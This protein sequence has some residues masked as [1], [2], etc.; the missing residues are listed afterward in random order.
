M[1][2][3]MTKTVKVFKENIWLSVVAGILLFCMGLA[4]WKFSLHIARI[5][6][7][8]DSINILVERDAVKSDIAETTETPGLDPDKVYVRLHENN[9]YLYDAQGNQVFGP[10]KSILLDRNYYYDDVSV[11]RYVDKNGLI[12]YG[13]VQNTEITIM[14]QGIYSKASRMVDGSACVKE[15]D[16]YYYIDKDGKRFTSGGYIDAYPFSESQGSYAR[17][18]KMDGSWSVI[19]R[20][21]EEVLSGF[22]S[23]DELPYCTYIGTGIRDGKVVIFTLEQ[24]EDQ[25]PHIIK[26][27]EECI[28]VDRYLGVDYILVIS[29]EG[30]QGVMNIWN[31]ES[32]APADYEDIQWGYMNIG[33]NTNIEIPWFQCQKA[34][35]TF[36]VYY[37]KKTDMEGTDDAYFE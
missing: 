19:N 22:E 31:G 34:D 32:V 1:K 14:S 27:V 2:N 25:Q 20:Q 6:Q 36:D 35:G 13:K 12:G 33:E 5:S 24:S 4:G 10:C 17:V 11:F 8:N 26:E 30:K 3:L 15:G 23:I 21:E 18:Q 9:A 29:K 28:E 7:N 37:G 16:E